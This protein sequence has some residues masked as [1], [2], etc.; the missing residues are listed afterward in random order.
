MVPENAKF[1]KVMDIFQSKGVIDVRFRDSLH[2][3]CDYRNSIHLNIM[4]PVD[5]HEGKPRRYNDAVRALHQLE[6]L[7]LD[8]HS[9]VE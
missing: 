4:E 1:K 6:S 8:F 3:L 9:G 2:G 7:L 5:L